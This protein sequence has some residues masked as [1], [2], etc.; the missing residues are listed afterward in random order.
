MQFDPALI[1]R[2]DMAAPRYTSYPTALSFDGAVRGDQW[3]AAIQAAPSRKLSL[4]VH[5]PF[6]REMCYYC[7]CN[8]IVT[9]HSHKAD[10]YLDHLAKEIAYQAELFGPFTVHHLHLG[11]GTPTFLSQQQMRRLI[12]LLKGHFQFADDFIGAI[13]VDPRALEVD[14]LTWLAEL[15]FSRLSM[16]AQDFD[17]KVQA[18]INRIQSTEKIAAIMARARTLGFSSI[19]LDFIYGL[20]HQNAQS[21]GHTLEQALALAPDRFS[22]FNYAHLPE[23]FPAQRRIKED[24]MPGPQEK[25]RM[26]GVTIETLTN[27][28]YHFIGMDHFAKAGDELALAQQQGR[29][30]RN[31]QGYTTDGDCELLALGASAISKVGGLYVQ[32]EKSIKD[33]QDATASQ[34]H[35]RAKGYQMSEDDHIRAAAIHNLL[36]HFRL[37]WAALDAR[38]GIDSRHYFSDDCALLAPFISDGLVEVDE[39]GLGVTEQGRLL[40]RTIATAFDVHLRKTVQQHRFSRVI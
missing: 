25:L 35:A 18:A 12:G 33:Y 7:G 38:F 5:I 20:P 32:N 8:K 27:A 15:G 30:H 14:D 13:E 36:C 3:R 9:R 31:F 40:V 16:G 17:P 10:I 37:D 19:N 28:G 29:L 2:Y 24:T 39:Q 26:Q 23:R 22:I 6:C 4:Y 21:F 34:G 11:G 1:R